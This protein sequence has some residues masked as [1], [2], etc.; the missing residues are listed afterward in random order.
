MYTCATDTYI[1]KL[2]RCEMD[3]KRVGWWRVIAGVETYPLGN[4]RLT[5]KVALDRAILTGRIWCMYLDWLFTRELQT[6]CLF[7]FIQ[8][9]VR[10]VLW[11]SHRPAMRPN[12]PCGNVLGLSI[13]ENWNDN[14]IEY[15]GW[16]RCEF[17]DYDA[18][19]QFRVV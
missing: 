10:A 4:G 19:S 1:T 13:E 8:R 12:H 6:D 18:I 11:C 17:T 15:E 16:S 5:M 9:N 7:K 2:L 3:P 14:V